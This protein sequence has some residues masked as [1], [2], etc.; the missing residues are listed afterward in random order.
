MGHKHTKEHKITMANPSASVKQST[1][2]VATT[3]TAQSTMAR[4][5]LSCTS[6]SLFQLSYWVAPRIPLN[7]WGRLGA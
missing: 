1:V 2:A 7:I 6:G 5:P 4:L 3:A